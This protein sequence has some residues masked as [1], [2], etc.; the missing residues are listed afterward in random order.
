MSND[1]LI[2]EMTRELTPVR[3]RTPSLT[4]RSVFR[5]DRRTPA[6]LSLGFPCAETC[7]KCCISRL[8]AE[9]RQPRLACD[10]RWDSCCRFPRAD[11]ASASNAARYG[12][13]PCAL[14]PARR[15]M[16]PTAA[17]MP[18]RLALGAFPRLFSSHYQRSSG[19]PCGCGDRP[20]GGFAAFKLGR[21]LVG[22]PQS[23]GHTRL[24]LSRVRS[25]IPGAA[26]RT[27]SFAS[28]SASDVGVSCRSRKGPLRQ[29][30]S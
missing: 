16:H 29:S 6:I 12:G 14:S 28:L 8:L 13:F 11:P 2:D 1:R 3:R 9:A 10:H 21:G 25:P 20:S 24:P 4:A 5:L 27:R 26:G 22:R 30:S 15:L 17:L 18:C 19:E 23:H 7:R